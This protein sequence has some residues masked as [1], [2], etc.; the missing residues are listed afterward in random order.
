MAAKIFGVSSV[1][2]GYEQT[3][4]TNKFS[5][6]ESELKEL[7][8]YE[9]KDIHNLY[10]LSSNK[11]WH[12]FFD[13]KNDKKTLLTQ[14]K[15]AFNPDLLFI[16][17]KTFDLPFPLAPKDNEEIQFGIGGTIEWL[18]THLNKNTVD[19]LFY[20]KFMCTDQSVHTL[21][22]QIKKLKTIYSMPLTQ[23]DAKSLL[24]TA[25]I[26]N[27]DFFSNFLRIAKDHALKDVDY[28]IAFMDSIELPVGKSEQKE[29]E[30]TEPFVSEALGMRLKVYFFCTSDKTKSLFEL[31]STLNVNDYDSASAVY[32]EYCNYI[33][34]L[35]TKYQQI[36]GVTGSEVDDFFD[37]VTRQK[38]TMASFC[39][40]LGN[41][42]SA[43]K[44]HNF[45]PHWMPADR[46][47]S[48]A[49]INFETR[50]QKP[51][52]INPDSHDGTQSSS[53]LVITKKSEGNYFEQSCY[54]VNTKTVEVRKA[55]NN[56]ASQDSILKEF[57][58]V[59][60]SEK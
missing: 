25:K 55:K 28:F 58:I 37:A 60:P 35:N 27:K 2:T 20:E 45:R 26:G 36:D 51:I 44:A 57:V 3:K 1:S 24:F 15:I 23:L 6:K 16:C 12:D 30:S 18:K 53:K 33:E 41:T 54:L 22:H 13:E 31:L 14:A 48:L 9:G 38:S 11:T 10:Q 17:F 56:L 52:S 21:Y 19:A 39:E 49:K 42:F 50:A 32:D 34:E 43:M 29:L 4:K 8:Y 47:E 40:A 46:C 59:E 5:L 7:C